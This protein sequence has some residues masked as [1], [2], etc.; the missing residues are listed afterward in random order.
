MGVF[1]RIRE[2]NDRRTQTA[3][4][5]QN[6]RRMQLESLKAVNER[7][8]ES[9][10]LLDNY[11]D[12][13]DAFNDDGKTWIPLGSDQ[14]HWDKHYGVPFT[15]QDDHDRIRAY[16]RLMANENEFAA[17]ELETRV[18]YIV[19]TGHVYSVEPKDED[20]IL[21]D[22]D[23]ANVMEV[24]DEFL[25]ENKWHRR[26]QEIQ[27]RLD[28]DGEVFLRFFQVARQANASADGVSEQPRR[29]IKVRF[30]EPSQVRTPPNLANDPAATF[31]IRTDPDDVETIEFYY[32]DGDPIDA[33]EIQHRKRNVDCNVKRGLPLLYQSKQSLPQAPKVIR[34]ASVATEIQVAVGMI[35]K[36]AAAS[37]SAVQSFVSGQRDAYLQQ[38]TPA[39]TTKTH[40][41]QQFQP[42]TILDV[43]GT[44]E[45]E[46]PAAGI[47][48]SKP[49]GTVQM[50]LRA[51]GARACMPEFM[52][53]GDA[54]NANYSSTLVAEGPAVKMFQR[55]Q[56]TLIEEDMEIFDRV[57]ELA[58]RQ[59]RLSQQLVDR[60]KICAEPPDVISRNELEAT[61]RREVLYKNGIL[62]AQTWSLE[63]NLDYEREQANND[64]HAEAHGGSMLLP[65]TPGDIPVPPDEDVAFEHLGPGDD[66]MGSHDQSTHGSG[67]GSAGSG[68]E[69]NDA[70]KRRLAA[71]LRDAVVAWDDDP[72]ERMSTPT[73]DKMVLVATRVFR[74][75]PGVKEVRHLTS[76]AGSDY[77]EL[78]PEKGYDVKV[79]ISNHPGGTNSHESP[80]WSFEP[81][82]KESWYRLGLDAIEQAVANEI[83]N[84]GDE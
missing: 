64:E 41:F 20:D 39:G 18:S 6:T 47:D 23:R 65:M 43:P 66:R 44:T 70:I 15:T 76:T 49:A 73:R 37:Q 36:H 19:G 56:W 72:D 80:A 67:G 26:Q 38:K 79:R 8:M 61:K 60:I 59:G 35:R 53:S 14:A 54:S 46:F 29:S 62:S 58:V 51:V 50:I 84:A 3:M 81:G 5:E 78:S 45:Y 30:V 63:E 83:E 17:G 27:R 11:V 57:L 75:I 40:N 22:A 32:V 55:E 42:G 31:G 24:V 52:I 7:L 34:N 12:P 69:W 4:L 74:E 10:S 48:P 33:K 25:D 71:D 1:A 68:G 13:R 9:F 21:S 2:W 82:H 77:F 28:R 16:C